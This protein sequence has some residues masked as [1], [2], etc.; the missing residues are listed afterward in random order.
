MKGG[1]SFMIFVGRTELS[2]VEKA[3]DRFYIPKS[4]ELH[5]ILQEGGLLHASLGNISSI[6]RDRASLG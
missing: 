5:N 3:F 4:G 2:L 1:D 6:F